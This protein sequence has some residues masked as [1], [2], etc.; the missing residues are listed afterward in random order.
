M[1]AGY[2]EVASVNPA[3]WIT[4]VIPNNAYNAN[5]NL[6][7]LKC[8]LLYLGDIGYIFLIYKQRPKKSP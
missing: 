4:K 1:R 6:K 2:G 7:S 5:A 3:S 8:R